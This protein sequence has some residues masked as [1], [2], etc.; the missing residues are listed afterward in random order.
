V[1]KFPSRSIVLH[2]HRH[3]EIHMEVSYVSGTISLRAI[4]WLELE[5]DHRHCTALHC[6]VHCITLYRIAL[7][8]D[9]MH[10]PRSHDLAFT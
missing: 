5:R 2:Q 9:R 10:G 6:T 7:F 8:P 3:M 4:N 1:T